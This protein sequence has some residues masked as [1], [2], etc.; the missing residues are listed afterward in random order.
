MREGETGKTKAARQ[1][2]AGQVKKDAN[3][4]SSVV[5]QKV[6]QQS[7]QPCSFFSEDRQDTGYLKETREKWYEYFI[8]QR[9]RERRDRKTVAKGS[10]R[11]LI[12]IS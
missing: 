9:E 1:G 3:G 10:G 6:T 8:K 4:D 12:Y 11:G 7:Y 5:L 2:G